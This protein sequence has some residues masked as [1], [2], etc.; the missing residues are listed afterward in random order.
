MHAP[1][2]ETDL[3]P[4]VKSFLEARGFEVKAEV[5]GCDVVARCGN[6]A[7]LIVELKLGF[8]LQLIYQAVDRLALSDHVYIAVAPAKRGLPA[9]A[10]KLCRRLG[11]GLIIV[12]NSGS[13]EVLAEPVRY[14]PRKST[15]RQ[16][17]LL[18]EF[19]KRKGDPNL[20]GSGGIKL[21]TAYKQDALRCL[22]HLSTHG[23]SKLAT[24]REAT[25]VGRAANIMRN[26]YYG[27][28]GRAVRGVYQLTSEGQAARETFAAHISALT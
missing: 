11:L 14:T 2:R 20:G 9:Q 23:P 26:N 17:R 8:S 19:T 12:K 1:M 6:D 16:Q 22:T 21:M 7:P 3:Y 18:K 28:F 5:N 10:V 25:K 24:L 15:S 27:W 13:V 4:A